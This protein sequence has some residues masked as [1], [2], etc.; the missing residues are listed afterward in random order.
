MSA[1]GS[2]FWKNRAENYNKTSWV[3]NDDFINSFLELLPHK[4]F[5]DILEVGVGTGVVA[6]KMVQIFDS[7]IGLDSS[8]E[9]MDSIN[10][11]KITTVLG[12][13]HSL[14]FNS[15]QFDLIYMRNVVHY[16]NDAEKCFN[17]I[18]NCL[19]PNGYL[20]FSQV[21]PFE[22]S[23]SE[24][25]DWLIG[26][27]IH[28]PTQTEILNW[29]N[30]FSILKKE[31]F[32]LNSQSIMNW[33]NNTAKNQDEIEKSIQRHEATSSNYKSLVKYKQE[34]DDLFVDIKHFMVL[35]QK[36]E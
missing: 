16:L 34:N 36:T 19:K 5:K 2:E 9:M 10:N 26:R 12:D 29:M 23:I 7:V 27:N 8:Q 22:D 15:N 35:C 20:L 18:L 24:E 14:P 3:K 21:V 11:P 31:F 25:Y 13:A 30:S 1:S 4:N 33:L 32:I 28:Y 17:E 6:T